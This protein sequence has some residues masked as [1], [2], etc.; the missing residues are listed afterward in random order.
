MSFHRVI[1]SAHL[2]VHSTSVILYVF[3]SV[4]NF[5]SR[6]CRFC[7]LGHSQGFNSLV[8]LL[9][10]LIV[11]QTSFIHTRWS[12]PAEPILELCH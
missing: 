8:E 2:E 9:L 1:N 6:S 10:L 7:N 4:A 5:N 3:G 11:M 12:V